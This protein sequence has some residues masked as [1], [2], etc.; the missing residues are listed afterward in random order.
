MVSTI[1]WFCRM[2]PSHAKKTALP[3]Q[4]VWCS[5]PERTIIFFAAQT[6]RWPS[7]LSDGRWWTI[8]DMLPPDHLVQR[9]VKQT[10]CCSP[11]QTLPMDV[12]GNATICDCQPQ[13]IAGNILHQPF[14]EIWNGEVMTEHRRRMLESN[15]PEA[16]KICP[17][18]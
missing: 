13:E 12:R 10:W 7:T 14:S 8:L 5:S 4:S 11:W 16:C 18:F 17:R 2:K 1:T 3:A 6:V 15:P 9:S